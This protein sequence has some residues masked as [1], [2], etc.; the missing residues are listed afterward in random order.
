MRKVELIELEMPL[1]EE[2]VTSFGS[3][4]YRPCILVRIEERG[5]EEG[6]GE[7][8]AGK[9]PLYSYETVKTAWHVIEDFLIP[10]LEGGVE[11]YHLR[12]AKFRGHNMA[13]AGLEEALWD[14]EARLAGKPL[15]RYLGGIKKRI[16][17]GVSIGIKKTVRKLLSEIEKYINLGYMRIKVKIKPGWDVEVV[18][19]IRRLWP[20]IPLQVDANAAYTLEHLK[21]LRALD[22]F[23]LNM[24]EQ[25][26][27]HD[28]LI[29]HAELAKKL[30]TPI[31]LDESI[32][33]PRHAALAKKLGSCRII[34]IKPGRVGGLHPS[35][36]IHDIWMPG[37]L[38]IGGMLETGI[39]RAH[40]VAMASLPGI[41][42][43]SDISASE[44]YY[45]RDVV[46][47]PWEVFK[48]YIDVPNDVG[49]G[50][51]ILES[52][53]KRHERKRKEYRLS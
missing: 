49:I 14:L 46:E 26:L 10:E 39:G 13:K 53:I 19:E 38:W 51:Q 20:D 15:A 17:V 47:P 29:E 5:G 16:P 44:R 35:K 32:K 11:A 6:W 24:I 1:K 36:K 30:R 33:E 41:N 21:A 28:D 23:N 7:V 40:L 37:G 8:A 9:A 27:A 50:V 43:P 25:P 2:F 18:K 12:V 22:E 48:G 3:I 42:M 31:C 52:E 34:N 4:K 45:E